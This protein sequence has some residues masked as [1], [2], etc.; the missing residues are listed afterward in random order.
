MHTALRGKT[1]DNRQITIICAVKYEAH[2]HHPMT[3]A[4][5]RGVI[6]SQINKKLLPMRG[7][8]SCSLTIELRTDRTNHASFGKHE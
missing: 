2:E 5:V 4:L 8:E 3:G 7:V 6:R 1:V